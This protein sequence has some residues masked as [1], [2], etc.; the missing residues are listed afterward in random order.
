MRS[1][2]IISMLAIGT[3]LL[4]SLGVGSAYAFY[5]SPPGLTLFTEN[6]RGS[7]V[8]SLATEIG[9]AA[10]D[11]TAPVTGVT[12]YTI[13]VQQFTDQLHSSFG[14]QYNTLGVRPV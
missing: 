8:T 7:D 2:S 11:G 6:L 12:H 4:L 1:K 10:P 14:C 3:A 5:Q 13:G 9:I